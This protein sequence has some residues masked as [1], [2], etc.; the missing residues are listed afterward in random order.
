MEM[1]DD[2]RRMAEAFENEMRERLDELETQANMKLDH[3]VG[4]MTKNSLSQVRRV[5]VSAAAVTILGLVLAFLTAYT[6][7][8]QE[9]NEA[10]TEFREDASDIQNELR[11]KAA[12]TL[13]RMNEAILKTQDKMAQFQEGLAKAYRDVEH[14]RKEIESSSASLAEA[15][16]ALALAEKELTAQKE[17]FGDSLKRTESFLQ[18]ISELEKDMQRAN[19]R[20]LASQ[21]ELD[22]ATLQLESVRNSLQ[23]NKK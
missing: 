10:I 20:L 15:R 14:A 5:I 3:K 23:Q 7:A 11:E 17:R 9:M 13:D 12:N 18:G 21:S 1:I 22:K 2:L 4:E 6:D 8:K 19:E 16:T